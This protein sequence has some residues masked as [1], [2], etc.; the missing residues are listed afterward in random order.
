MLTNL[1]HDRQLYNT[2]IPPSHESPVVARPTNFTLEWIRELTLR[3]TTPDIHCR[4]RRHECDGGIST[5]TAR[6]AVKERRRRRRRRLVKM[7][8][9]I[10]KT[11]MLQTSGYVLHV[12]STRRPGHAVPPGSAANPRTSVSSLLRRRV[13]RRR[14]LRVVEYHLVNHVDGRL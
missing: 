8:C 7:K 1:Y 5:T 12:V 3:Y 2:L 9:T 14:G 6:C 13:D 11:N 10:N 4:H